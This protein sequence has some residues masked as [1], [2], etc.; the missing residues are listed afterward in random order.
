MRS[1]RLPGKV[2]RDLAGRPLLQYVL[3][4]LQR[5]RA[6]ADVV[7]ATSTDR[8]DD[9]VAEFCAARGISCHRGPL[10]DVAG[11]FVEVVRALDLDACVRVSG[12][13][14]LLDPGLVDRGTSLFDHS[15]DLVTNVRARTFP[16]GQSVEVVRGEALVDA[17]ERMVEPDDREHVTTLFY[18]EPGRYRIQSFEAARP[19]GALKLSVDT[20]DELA[21]VAALIGRMKRPHWE[22]GLDEI[23]RLAAAGS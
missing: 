21:A 17:Y 5:C 3:E 12:D 13:S 1:Q 19:Y 2:L 11:R 16:P 4:R 15:V 7:V 23:A 9:P 8:S 6:L 20:E 14:P 10:E 18:R 22:Y